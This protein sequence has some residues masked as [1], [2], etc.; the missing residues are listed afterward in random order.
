MVTTVRILMLGFAGVATRET[1]RRTSTHNPMGAG[2][3]AWRKGCVMSHSDARERAEKIR[4]N[5]AAL[6][7]DQRTELCS[8]LELL[9]G[10]FSDRLEM[11]RAGG[12]VNDGWAG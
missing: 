2:R 8:V 1:G 4:C 3:S 12:M 11:L 10:H 9:I 5:L 6:T 7:S